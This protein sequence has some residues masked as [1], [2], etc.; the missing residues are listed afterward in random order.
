MLP[1]QRP[2]PQSPLPQNASLP[3]CTVR[4][5][6]MRAARVPCRASTT[7]STT[8]DG[9]ATTFATLNAG[10]A[11]F[12]DASTGLWE[13]MWGDHLHHGYYPPGAPPKSNRQAQ[14]DMIEETLKW[15]GV[16]GAKK[17]RPR[18]QYHV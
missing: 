9:P 12:Y 18:R 4:L 3:T 5:S 17:V 14:E 10:I 13:N 2:I 7:E 1:N 11:K 15:A 8:A 6:P 16:T